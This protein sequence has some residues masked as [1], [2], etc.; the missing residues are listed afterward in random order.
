MN[1]TQCITFTVT[2][3][4]NA[5]TAVHRFH[6]KS[7]ELIASEVFRQISDLT[8]TQLPVKTIW[9]GHAG[10]YLSRLAAI[11]NG[12]QLVAPAFLITATETLDNN[13]QALSSDGSK[14]NN[15]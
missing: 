10:L 7:A 11:A 5:L 13:S 2:S 12:E 4:S 15:G 1:N 9:C 8:A 14:E 6:D 3:L